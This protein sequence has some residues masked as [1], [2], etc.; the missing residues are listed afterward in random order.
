VWAA[1]FNVPAGSYDYKAAFNDS[2]SESYG[3]G[4]VP[5]GA[6]IGL[7][8]GGRQDVTFRYSPE[9]H[10]VTDGVH[11]RIV[12]AAG[13]FQSELGCPGDWN[14]SCLRSW[15]QDPDGDGT[16]SFTTDL[17][18][19]GGRGGISVNFKTIGRNGVYET[20]VTVKTDDPQQAEVKLILR[21]DVRDLIQV[22]PALLFWKSNEERAAKS[23]EFL[24]R[25]GAVMKTV[26]VKL[27][28]DSLEARVEE[29]RKGSSYR[30]IVI[31][32]GFAV[33]GLQEVVSVVALADGSQREI[34]TKVRVVP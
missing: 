29:L 4:R 34:R 32:R 9:T 19:P 6:N 24:S 33:D 26:S 23:V 30:L 14:P 15:L 3:A 21:A 16:Y 2:L 25:E 8:L 27:V 31:P 11:S 18:P 5:N 22:R 10:W 17:I 28:P 20:P 7:P 1:S 13:S 12:T